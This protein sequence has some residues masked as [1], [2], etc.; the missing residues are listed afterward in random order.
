MAGRGPLM[1]PGMRCDGR[2]RTVLT[3][4]KETGLAGA[5]L[6]ARVEAAMHGIP[7]AEL[8]VVLGEIEHRART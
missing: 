7:E 8:R 1:V 2:L 4:V 3:P 5:R 6:A